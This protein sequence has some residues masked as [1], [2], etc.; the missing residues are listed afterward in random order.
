[1]CDTNWSTAWKRP[2]TDNQ[3]PREQDKKGTT[4]RPATQKKQD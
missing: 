4:E 3:Q 1:M 2:R